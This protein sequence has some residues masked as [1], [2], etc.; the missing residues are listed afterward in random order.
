M[1]SATAR[2]RTR[3]TA[4]SAM[5]PGNGIK[6]STTI[7]TPHP[8]RQ[9]ESP[10]CIRGHSRPPPAPPTRPPPGGPPAHGT[11]TRQPARGQT[12]DSH[13]GLGPPAQTGQAP[14]R[15]RRT[16]DRPPPSHRGPTADPSPPRTP[17]HDTTARQPARPQTPDS[18]R[19]A[20]ATG[21]NGAGAAAPPAHPGPAAPVTP[22]TPARAPSHRDASPAGG[23]S[24]H[25]RQ[26]PE[27]ARRAA[28]RRHTP[29][30]LAPG[31]PDRVAPVTPVTPPWVPVRAG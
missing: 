26:P 3:H 4:L 23:T 6:R 24:A 16:P 19:R 2:E 28:A 18:H 5:A 10:A 22:V 7:R 9:T 20:R 31:K 8:P 15:P 1:R 14:P 29:G 21:T 27:R 17:T 30:R 13:R 25:A 12:P 11:T